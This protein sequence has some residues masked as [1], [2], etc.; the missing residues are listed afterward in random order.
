MAKEKPK[1]TTLQYKHIAK[2]A[3]EAQYQPDATSAENYVVAIMK[4]SRF[5]R[6]N[7][8]EPTH[9]FKKTKDRKFV[10]LI[11]AYEVREVNTL[12]DGTTE[13]TFLVDDFEQV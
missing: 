7:G 12:A 4:A 13:I 5:I 11:N 10:K 6:E 9:E 3:L 8:L 1:G 2:A